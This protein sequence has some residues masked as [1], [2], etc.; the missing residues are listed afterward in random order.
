M[1][2]AYL[3]VDC[4]F[5]RWLLQRIDK[6][7]VIEHT[8]NKMK[9]LNCEKI[10]AGIYDCQENAALIETLKKESVGGVRSS[11]IK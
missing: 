2:I 3:Q 6:K 9:E 5:N 4:R 11:I 1:N 7:Y 10:V 8:L